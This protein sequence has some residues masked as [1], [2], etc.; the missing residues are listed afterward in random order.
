MFLPVVGG[1]TWA[2]SVRSKYDIL[3]DRPSL[4][5]QNSTLNATTIRIMSSCS[6]DQENMTI[7]LTD[8]FRSWKAT[9]ATSSPPEP[10]RDKTQKRTFAAQP[11][12]QSPCHPYTWPSRV[13]GLLEEHGLGHIGPAGRGP[14][15]Q[16]YFRRQARA[17]L[18]L[19]QGEP[20]PGTLGSKGMRRCP[21]YEDYLPAWI[22]T[23]PP[24][25]SGGRCRAPSFPGLTLL[26]LTRAL[27]IGPPP[28]I[29]RRNRP[30]R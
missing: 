20:C 25:K 14:A 9:E 1:L 16:S 7:S 2:S 18:R 17:E 29:S 11:L 27:L 15:G 30:C 19:T 12:G 8:P 10:A 5:S 26:P 24:V 4:S 3:L 22:T 23:L 21:T 28:L 6:F 13:V